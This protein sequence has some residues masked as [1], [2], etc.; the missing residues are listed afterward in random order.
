M[1]TFVLIH[2]SWHA[3]WCWYK[4]A[5]RLAAAGHA[6]HVP[7]LPAHGGNRRR[8]PGLVTL[9]AMT[10]TVTHIL[11]GLDEPAIVV[12]H[13]RGGIV[14][15]SVA[16]RRPAKVRGLVYLAAFLLR[17]GERVVDRFRADRDSMIPGHLE[18]RRWAVTD[19]LA[20]RAYR[21][22][23]YADCGADDITLATSLLAPEPSLPA[24]TRLR[25]TAARYGSVPRYYIELLHDRAV[26]LAAQRAMHTASPCRRVVAIDASHSAYFSRP[27]ELVAHLVE[28]ADNAQALCDGGLTACRAADTSPLRNR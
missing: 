7:D 2:G 5:S 15:S 14:A 10:R 17:D 11:D 6:V 12:A 26:S 22:A 3:A 24:L 28:I 23:L 25:L 1:A 13:S 16:E 21:E 9:G 19:M 18:V 27:D 8:I 4:V 20:A